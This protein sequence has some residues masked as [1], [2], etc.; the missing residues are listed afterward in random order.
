MYAYSKTTIDAI[1]NA[2][3]DMIKRDFDAH[4]IIVH[5]DMKFISDDV[6]DVYDA[7]ITICQELTCDDLLS[8][9]AIMLNFCT[10]DET[11]YTF[12]CN[13]KRYVIGDGD[14]TSACT[15]RGNVIRLWVRQ[16]DAYEN[17]NNYE[18]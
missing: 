3:H 4:N 11:H 18:T 2:C 7:Q 17:E 1:R 9:H 16:F 6:V 14:D 12:M 15:M 10:H 5:V 13:E 8:L